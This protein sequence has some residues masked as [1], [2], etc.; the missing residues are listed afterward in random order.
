VEIRA[1]PSNDKEAMAKELSRAALVILLS[2]FETHP[3]AV[4][5]ALFL[6]RPVLVA[7]TSGLS[8]I[9][10]KGWARAIPLNSSPSEIAIAAAEQIANP[11]KQV[12]IKLPTWDDCSTRL[13]TLY[14]SLVEEPA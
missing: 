12:N 3:I 6:G 13:L 11:V 1:I 10:A 9:A 4:L 2:E 14:Q 5:E 8:E 7:D